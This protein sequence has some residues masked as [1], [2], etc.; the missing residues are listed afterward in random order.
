MKKLSQVLLSLLLT[1][2]IVLGGCFAIYKVIEADK[3]ENVSQKQEE[4]VPEV[5]EEEEKEEEEIPEDEIVSI[6][7]SAAGDVTLG[8]TQNQS[9][10]GSFIQMFDNKGSSYFLSNVK[11]VFENDD[12][13]LVNFEGVLTE[14]TAKVEKEFNLKG[15]PEFM[16]ILNDG[17][18]ECAGFS[19]NH[20]L[21]YYEQGS[22]DTIEGFKNYGITYACN[23]TV[24]V[25][26]VKGIKMGFIA[27]NHC[28]GQD[29]M[30]YVKN[31]IVSLKESGANCVIVIIH[32]GIERDHYPQQEQIQLAHNMIDLGVDLVIGS[33]PHV[34]QGVEIYNGKAICYS[35]G[36]FCF[37]GN[38]NPSVKDTMIYQQTFTFI[39]GELKTNLDATLIP[40][41][42][43]S[44]DSRND[45]QPTVQTGDRKSS[46][47]EELREYS[48]Q[49]DT[50]IDDDG[51]IIFHSCSLVHDTN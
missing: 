23:D 40:C 32:W 49:F 27:V 22:N 34:L 39:N 50:E 30:D 15:R 44:T 7:L 51:N 25:Y 8:N 43:S 28:G 42:I 48:S 12:M 14:A 11:S 13:T 21:D 38:K 20:R 6:T 4:T 2:T 35:M 9:Y 26:E 31:G 41:T 24:G 16:Q 47:I 45:F 10:D 37:G 1:I 3:K 5:Q 17:S 46:I 18:V 33:H 36:N 29:V 19:N